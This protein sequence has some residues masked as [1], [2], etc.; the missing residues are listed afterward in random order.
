M[1]FLSYLWIILGRGMLV[2]DG[3]SNDG[4]EV[5]LSNMKICN[6]RTYQI[7]QIRRVVKFKE[8]SP[9]ITI[10]PQQNQNHFIKDMSECPICF[11]K[12][13][14]SEII[15][16]VNLCL[17]DDK[18]QDQMVATIPQNVIVKQDNTI[19]LTKRNLIVLFVLMKHQLGLDINSKNVDIVIV[20]IA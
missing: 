14:I 1:S 8:F 15:T 9:S 17:E 16:H 11:K 20:E 5:D 10:E 6:M 13:N 4:Y 12:F 19:L 7:H 2:V 18:P 3:F